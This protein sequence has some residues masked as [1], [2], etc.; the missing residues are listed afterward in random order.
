MTRVG[1]G[2]GRVRKGGGGGLYEYTPCCLHLHLGHTHSRAEGSTMHGVV[3]WRAERMGREGCGGMKIRGRK[4]ARDTAVLGWSPAGWGRTRGTSRTEAQWTAG[5]LPVLKLDCF[6]RQGR[7]LGLHRRLLPAP[8]AE[9]SGL[10]RTRFFPDVAWLRLSKRYLPPR[11]PTWKSFCTRSPDADTSRSSGSD[12]PVPS[13]PEAAGRSV[14]H[15]AFLPQRR[16]VAS[17]EL[18]AAPPR[19]RTEPLSST[20]RALDVHAS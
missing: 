3:A 12:L 8:E 5:L 7:A 1:Q 15:D 16:L 18:V 14:T 9:Y 19:P 6:N 17:F 10:Q 4:H 13:C 20:G 2:A 11:G